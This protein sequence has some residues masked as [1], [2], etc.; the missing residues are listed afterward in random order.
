MRARAETKI[1][2]RIFS[3][4]LLH[5][6]HDIDEPARLEPRRR[7]M[8]QV[9]RDPPATPSNTQHVHTESVCR[10]G[11]FPSLPDAPKKRAYLSLKSNGKEANS[12]T[13]WH[14]RGEV[15]GLFFTCAS[16][17]GVS[18]FWPKLRRPLGPG[19]ALPACLT[20]ACLFSPQYIYIKCTYDARGCFMRHSCLIVQGKIFEMGLF[21]NFFCKQIKITVENSRKI[22]SPC[23]LRWLCLNIPWAFSI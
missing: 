14:R 20:W 15:A 2:M 19:V 1:V 3:F 10:W 17:L 13:I 4:S 7:I 18:V 6:E 16:P 9:E 22:E 5:D 11:R 23:P 8:Q 21:A 12:I